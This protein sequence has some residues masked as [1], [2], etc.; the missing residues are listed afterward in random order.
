VYFAFGDESAPSANLA[1]VLPKL[2]EIA[3]DSRREELL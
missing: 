1:K 2:R 3:A